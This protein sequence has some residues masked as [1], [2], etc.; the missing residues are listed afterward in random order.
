MKSTKKVTKKKVSKKTTKKV[1][2]KA[3]PKVKVK[4]LTDDDFYDRYRTDQSFNSD[5]FDTGEGHSDGRLETY[6]EDIK[7]VLRINK[8]N[9]KRVWTVVE[10][11]SGALYICAGYHLVNRLYYI[12]TKQEYK[13]SKEEYNFF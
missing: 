5:S 2:K 4:V 8:K 1:A 11:D 9:P 10:G 3:A 7:R 13:N 12:I 6:G